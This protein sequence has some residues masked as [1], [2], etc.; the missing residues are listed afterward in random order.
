MA[1]AFQQL[2]CAPRPHRPMAEQTTDNAALFASDSKRSEKVGDDIVVV[3]GIKRDVIATGINHSTHHIKSLVAV[4][5]RDLDGDD[6]LDFRKPT[7][8]VIRKNTSTDARLQIKPDD[9]N[10]FCDRL[11]MLN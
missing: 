10:D 6:V 9:R 1:A 8:E 11:T 4:E 3:A 2:D 5:R 7:P